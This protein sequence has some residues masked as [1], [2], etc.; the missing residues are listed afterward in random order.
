MDAMCSESI[1][2]LSSDKSLLD[3]LQFDEP[4]NRSNLDI[5]EALPGQSSN[6]MEVPSV[7]SLLHASGKCTPC[8]YFNRE[9]GCQKIE[10]CKFCHIRHQR[11][12]RDWPCKEW[13]DRFY[14][15]VEQ[16][17]KEIEEKATGISSDPDWVTRWINRLP[18]FIH[19]HPDLK[20]HITQSFITHAEN[21]LSGKATDPSQAWHRPTPP[22]AKPSSAGHRTGRSSQ[23]RAADVYKSLS[24][25]TSL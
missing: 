4:A 14:R 5:I 11:K 21:L 9:S 19:N 3:D 20:A 1:I 17:H 24:T 7:G 10:S 2:K 25:K 15:H 16:L 18:G 8:M 12:H 22:T 13:R 23:S 6:T